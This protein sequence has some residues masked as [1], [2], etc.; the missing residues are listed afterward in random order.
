MARFFAAALYIPLVLIAIPFAR[1]KCIFSFI[2]S[3]LF[4]CFPILE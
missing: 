1:K 2:H 4:G 3:G